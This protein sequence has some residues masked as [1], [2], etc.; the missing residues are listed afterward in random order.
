MS[1]ALQFAASGYPLPAIARALDVDEI[2]AAEMLLNA[3]QEALDASLPAEQ[4]RQVELTHLDMLR[5]SMTPLALRGDISAARILLRISA[6]RAALLHLTAP[7]L[8]DVD[9]DEAE[10]V[11]DLDRIRELRHSRRATA[12]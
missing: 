10:A 1:D 6:Q 11:S 2:R 9:A 7:A 4:A 8:P 5:R 3:T 12:N